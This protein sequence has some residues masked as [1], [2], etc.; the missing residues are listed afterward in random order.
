MKPD[1][2]TLLLQG[3]LEGCRRTREFL[4]QIFHF[5]MEKETWG[6]LFM[7]LNLSG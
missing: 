6:F 3:A 1:S 4:G 5:K 2:A 7:F